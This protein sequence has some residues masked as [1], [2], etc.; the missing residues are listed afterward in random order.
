MRTSSP[1]ADFPQLNALL[2]NYS[3]KAPKRQK[4]YLVSC[5]ELTSSSSCGC[6][7]DETYELAEH[8]QGCRLLKRAVHLLCFLFNVVW[9]GVS[10]RGSCFGGLWEE[11]VKRI[12]AM[13]V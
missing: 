5:V 7:F 13:Y 6:G 9:Y 10:V 1:R 12:P 8:M 3:E 11:A 4:A 2:S